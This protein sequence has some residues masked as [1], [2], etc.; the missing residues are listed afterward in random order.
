MGAFEY[1]YEFTR[2]AEGGLDRSKTTNCGITEATLAEA[3]KQGLVS[4]SIAKVENLK[5][6]DAEK[7]LREMF[8]NK[9]RGD[10]LPLDVAT[11]LFDTGKACSRAPGSRLC[12]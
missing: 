6:S 3:K 10:E 7:I 12:R 9:I 11:A 5:P 4:Q 8:W 2:K 1:A